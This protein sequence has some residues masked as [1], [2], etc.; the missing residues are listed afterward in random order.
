MMDKSNPST[1]FSAK[2][3]QPLLLTQYGTT[4]LPAKMSGSSSKIPQIVATF[5]A[6]IGAFALGT[7][8]AWSSPALPY[9]VECIEHSN[10]SVPINGTHPLCTIPHSF[11][12]EQG[13]W[14]GSL[15]PV[16]ALLGS[17]VWIEET[18][19]SDVEVKLKIQAFQ[20]KVELEIKLLRGSW[21]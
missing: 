17:Q 19:C 6:T 15:F 13:S 20:A 10:T 11:T 9:L 18:T 16:G 7:G 12:E 8:L 5:S 3:E 21:A 1:Q 14:I 4:L 2:L